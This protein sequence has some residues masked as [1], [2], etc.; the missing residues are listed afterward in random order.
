MWKGYWS[1][2][3]MTSRHLFY[4]LTMCFVCICNTNSYTKVTLCSCVFDLSRII[5]NF[6][7]STNKRLFQIS[8]DKESFNKAAPIYQKALNNSR[9]KHLLK[10]S[11]QTPTQTSNSRRKNRKREI[12]W[13]IWYSPPFSKNVSTYMGCTFLKLLEKEFTKEHVLHEI[14]NINSIKISYSCMP[15]LKQNI[16]GHNKFWFTQ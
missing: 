9:Y 4:F 12:I 10:F 11:W 8:Y 5:S 6:P 2:Q 13:Y 14:F 16:N 3:T 1:T 7:Q 15:N